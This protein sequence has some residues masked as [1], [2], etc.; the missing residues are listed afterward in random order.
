MNGGKLRM[1][2][3]KIPINNRS[4]LC[5]KPFLCSKGRNSDVGCVTSYV[6]S[7]RSDVGCVTSYVG[8]MDSYV[9]S[10]ESYVGNEDSDHEIYINFAIIFNLGAFNRFYLDEKQ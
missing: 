2:K 5:G 4:K 3:V 7:V 10:T 9:G 6:G 1:E 8:I